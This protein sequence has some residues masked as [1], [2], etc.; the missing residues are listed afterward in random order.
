MQAEELTD[1]QKE[2]EKIKSDGWKPY[3]IKYINDRVK[4]EANRLEKSDLWLC[5]SNMK[6]CKTLKLYIPF[7]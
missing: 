6:G 3:L 1:Q 5:A 4:R 2:K 7:S